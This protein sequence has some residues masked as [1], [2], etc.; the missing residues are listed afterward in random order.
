M[1]RDGYDAVVYDLDGTLVRLAV[2]WSAARAS[3]AGVF[4]DAGH[5]PGEA[6]LWGLLDRADE[7][8]DGLPARVTETVADH[9]RAGARDSE[10]LPLADEAARLAVD[11]PVGVLSL[12]AESAC[13][14]ALER[15]DLADR[16]GIVLGRDSHERRKP[17]PGPLRAA[18]DRLG[19]ERDRALF[20]GDS[21]SDR[22]CAKRAGVDFAFVDG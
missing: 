6:D 5:D 22:E 17:H 3:V 10:R 14:I 11:R 13:R 4:S 7:I 2:D 8:G 9:E 12:N 18:L 16:I 19:V 1:S 20:V 21:A 15:H